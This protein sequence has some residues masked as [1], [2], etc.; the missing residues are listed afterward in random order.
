MKPFLKPIKN[1]EALETGRAMEEEIKLASSTMGDN[2]FN[3]LRKSCMNLIRKTKQTTMVI[4][5]IDRLIE[6]MTEVISIN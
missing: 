4:V 5:M 6:M 2:C 3:N 1:S